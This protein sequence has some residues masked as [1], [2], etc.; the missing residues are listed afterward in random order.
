[1]AFD[2]HF[3]APTYLVDVDAADPV[4]LVRRL[5]KANPDQRP[6]LLVDCQQLRCLRTH[7]VSYLVSRLLLTRA[8]GA[9]LLLY[10]VGPSLLRSLKLLQLHQLFRIWPV[11]AQA[12]RQNALA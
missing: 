10:N 7:G 9:D 12:A 2:A 4:A 3:S 1:M 5:R 11:S 6:N 8:A